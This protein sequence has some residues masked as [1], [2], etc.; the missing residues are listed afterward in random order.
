MPFDGNIC[1]GS[2]NSDAVLDRLIDLH[3]A[4]RLPHAI[5]L[6]AED[7]SAADMVAYKLVNKILDCTDCLQHLDFFQISPEDTGGAQITADMVRNLI[8]NI[9]VSPKI[10]RLKVAYIAHADQMNKYAANSFLKT[11]EEPPG[12]TIIILSAKNPYVVLPT[13]LSRCV[14]FALSDSQRISSPVLDHI[15]N[16][17]ESWLEMLYSRSRK[18]LAIME[19][20]K[21]LS[22]IE[23]HLGELEA[24][25][26]TSIE[27]A[28]FK[29]LEI[30]TAKIFRAH[31]K[32]VQKLYKIISIF[33]KS[34]YFLAINC[35]LIAHLE[36][37]FI[38]IVKFFDDFEEQS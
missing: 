1:R 31:E 38:L 24:L 27:L 9:Q 17:Y 10:G 37:C 8:T 23:Q 29:T 36:R 15:A 30:S 35:N 4:N 18:N 3:A 34:R 2:N 16:T 7:M 21:L 33:E 6:L 20:Y 14:P 22:Y 28:L 11:L 32:S 26:K 25:D 5:L 12:D 13:I 19:M